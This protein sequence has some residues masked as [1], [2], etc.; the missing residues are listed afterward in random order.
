MSAPARRGGTATSRFGV[1]RRESHDAS[2]F[3]ERFPAPEIS[4]DSDITGHASRNEIWIGDARHMDDAGFIADNSVALVVTSPPY[5]AGKEYETAVGEGHVPADYVAYLAMLEA[6]FAEC[7][8]KLEPG[9]R[10][11]VNVANLGRRPYRSLSADVIGILQ[12]RL[13]LLLR[14]EVIW[15]KAEGAGGNCAWGSF[16]RP[17]NPVL[18]DVTERVIIASKGR[19]DRALSPAERTARGL[20]SRG[21]ANADEFMDA[22][23]DVWEIS[24]ESAT[25]VG[26]PAP[27][28]VELPERLIDLYTY[29]GDLILDPFMGSGTTAVAAI[30]TGRYY[31][32]FDTDGSYVEVANERIAEE[33]E[34]IRRGTGTPRWEAEGNT[35]SPLFEPPDADGGPGV[36]GSQGSSNGAHGGSGDDFQARAV[37]EGRKAQE[38]ARQVLSECGFS[39]IREKASFSCGVEVNFSALDQTGRR[40]LFDV[41]GAFSVTQRPG[42]RRT[43]TLWKALGKAAVLH[44]RPDKDPLVLL[45]TDRPV[46]N[47][48]GHRAL[49]AVTGTDNPVYAVIEMED[50]DDLRRL[51]ALADGGNSED[52]SAGAAASP[53]G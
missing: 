28:P 17:A 50:P 27:F 6:V 4:A 15:R 9:G 3:Y 19:F 52:G 48:A 47:S 46:P 30:R 26:H 12:D 38:K 11:A 7:V 24:A 53:E 1:S 36:A 40:W 10:I 25:R 45:T 5:F 44:S 32:G 34:R 23:I 33:A 29:R 14:G 49:Q 21:T 31:V 2:A 22:T 35:Q 51:A 18:R 37:R 8:R 42:L 13:G 41:S 20:P 39:Q 43:D 16:Q